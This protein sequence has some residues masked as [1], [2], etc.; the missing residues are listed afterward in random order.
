MD[1]NWFQRSWYVALGMWGLPSCSNDDH[2]L[3]WPTL[4]QGLTCFPMHLCIAGK[5]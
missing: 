3:P 4:P 2:G 5:F 1:I